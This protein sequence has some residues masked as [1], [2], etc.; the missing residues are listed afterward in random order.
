M[1]HKPIRVDWDD[2]EVAFDNPNRELIYYLDLVDGHVVL[3]GEGEEDDF[4]DEDAKYDFGGGSTPAAGTDGT[5]AYIDPLASETKVE[6]IVRF[7]AERSD[8]DPD[9]RAKLQSALASDDPAPAIIDALQEHPED[10]D[11]WYAF[12]ADC[13]HEMIEDWIVENGIA[14]IDPPPWKPAS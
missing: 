12:R 5:R 6:W 7:V 4:D 9:F 13:L 3:E 2:L 1:K 10:K 14:V 11:R 8:L